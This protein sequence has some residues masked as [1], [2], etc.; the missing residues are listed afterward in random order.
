MTHHV[1]KAVG[2]QYDNIASGK[3]SAMNRYNDRPEGYKIG[4]T[5]TLRKGELDNTVEGGFRYTGDEYDIV[6][7]DVDDFGC[8]PGYVTLSVNA[9][10]VLVVHDEELPE[11]LKEQG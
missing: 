4:D 6:I 2:K 7:T 11:C 8:Q 10:S 5:A 1:I 3:R 9:D